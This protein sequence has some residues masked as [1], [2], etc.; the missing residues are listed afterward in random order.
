MVHTFKRSPLYT[1]ITNTKTFRRNIKPV[2]WGKVGNKWNLKQ[3][4]TRNGQRDWTTHG[5]PLPHV[6]KF[7]TSSRSHY[8]KLFMIQ[9]VLRARMLN[10]TKVIKYNRLCFCEVYILVL[11]DN[12]QV[13]MQT[14]TIFNKPISKRAKCKDQIRTSMPS[15]N[16]CSFTDWIGTCSSCKVQIH[17]LSITS[18]KPTWHKTF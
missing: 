3:S 14:L 10:Y 11:A 2:P 1:Y 9:K 16:K 13:W 18:S 6:L 5:N 8:K 15:F 7:K 12:Y 17:C 4:W